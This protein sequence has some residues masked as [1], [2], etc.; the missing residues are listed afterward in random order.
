MYANAENFLALPLSLNVRPNPGTGRRRQIGRFQLDAGTLDRFNRLLVG[1]G[2]SQPLDCDQI[3]TAARCLDDGQAG[4]ATPDCIAQRLRQVDPVARLLNDGG[5][6]PVREAAPVLQAVQAY[7]QETDDLIPDA[8]PRIG[9]LDD[10][11]VIETAWPHISAEVLDYLDFCRLRD[12]E[13]QLRGVEPT[14]FGFTR[15]EWEVSRRAEAGLHLHQR[16]VR[17]GSFV[18]KAASYFRVH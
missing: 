13:A 15:S 12:I 9:R 8:M 7:V 1:L 10:A 14:A 5:W 4:D 2:R 3:V 11:I 16:R 17:E 6:T 18:P